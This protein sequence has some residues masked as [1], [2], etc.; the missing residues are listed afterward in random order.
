MC[1]VAGCSITRKNQTGSHKILMPAGLCPLLPNISI[2]HRKIAIVSW[3]QRPN[4]NH[5]P[6]VAGSLP[7]CQTVTS[8]SHPQMRINQGLEI[9]YEKVLSPLWLLFRTSPH[10]AL[11]L[12]LYVLQYFLVFRDLRHTH[13]RKPSHSSAEKPEY[14]HANEM[15]AEVLSGSH[16]VPGFIAASGTMTKPFSSFFISLNES[17][18]TLRGK[19]GHD[20]VRMFQQRSNQQKWWD[21]EI[22]LQTRIRKVKAITLGCLIGIWNNLLWAELF[23]WDSR[24]SVI[25]FSTFPSIRKSLKLF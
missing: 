12:F 21:N 24:N 17:T 20:K 25:R 11:S 16:Y 13:R 7:V 15:M 5:F 9:R 19:L 10:L 8:Q 3:Y 4:L 23:P 14:T 18:N 6:S 2:K 22:I 1:E